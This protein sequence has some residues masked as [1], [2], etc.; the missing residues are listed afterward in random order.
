M[1]RRNLITILIKKKTNIKALH[2]LIGPKMGLNLEFFSQKLLV[3]M[4][5]VFGRHIFQ[6]LKKNPVQKYPKELI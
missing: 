1:G 3:E 5:G 4:N 6:S 2:P